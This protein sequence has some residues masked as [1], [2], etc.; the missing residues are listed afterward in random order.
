MQILL[1]FYMDIFSVTLEGERALEMKSTWEEAA[2]ILII[3]S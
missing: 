2:K 3:G 1:L